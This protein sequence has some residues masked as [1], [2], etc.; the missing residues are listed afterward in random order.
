MRYIHPRFTYLLMNSVWSEKMS[1]NATQ[2]PS[3]LLLKLAIIIIIIIIIS[4][5]IIITTLLLF[6]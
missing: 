3:G 5:T 4:A 1:M 6:M 2:L